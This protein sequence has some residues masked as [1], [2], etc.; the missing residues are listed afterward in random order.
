MPAATK[1][2][3][4]IKPAVQDLAQVERTGPEGALPLR[5][6]LLAPAP[7]PQSAP[8]RMDL[9]THV[10]RQIVEV[11]Q[12]LPGRPVEISLSPEELG[13]VR[14]SVSPTEAGLTV[15]VAADRPET[16]DLMRRH[17]QTLAQEFGAIGYGDVAFSFSSGSNPTSSTAAQDDPEQAITDLP[18]D[19]P[20]IKKPTTQRTSA[21]GLD[22]RL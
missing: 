22:L 13:R 11:A 20:T 18:P 16:L 15:H 17:I 8:T 9:P 21:E 1:P 6:D 14:L 12:H 19:L 3:E 10:A 2:T 4:P 5:S 7:P